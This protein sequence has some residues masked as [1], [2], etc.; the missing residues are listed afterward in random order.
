MSDDLTIKQNGHDIFWNGHLCEGAD[1]HRGIFLL[2]TRCGK[3]DVPAG[4]AWERRPEDIV[5]CA[6]C[7]SKAEAKP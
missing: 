1:V 2:W 4:K 5:T 3:H 6:A 7:L